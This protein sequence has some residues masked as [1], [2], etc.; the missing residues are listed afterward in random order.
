[1]EAM[2]GRGDATTGHHA[3]PV[4]PGTVP[5]VLPAPQPRLPGVPQLPSF[6]PFAPQQGPDS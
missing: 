3:A 1:M 5:M 6:L 2:E 4:P